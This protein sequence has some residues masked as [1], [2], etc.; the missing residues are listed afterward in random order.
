MKNTEQVTVVAI[1]K[2][3][4]SASD[5]A[6]VEMKRYYEEQILAEEARSVGA[7]PDFFEFVSIFRD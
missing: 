1:R 7:E 5:P 4:S 6:H 2:P 3:R